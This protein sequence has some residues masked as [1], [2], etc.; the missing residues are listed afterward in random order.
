MLYLT[1]DMLTHIPRIDDAHLS[2]VNQA[3]VVLTA[4]KNGEAQSIMNESI[5]F[6]EKYLSE[7][8]NDEEEL[9]LEMEYPYYYEHHKAHEKIIQQMNFLMEE[10][11]VDAR[12]PKTKKMLIDLIFGVFFDH[13][14]TMDKSLS[15]FVRH[16]K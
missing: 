8:F 16:I 12:S 14:R 10:H 9:Q 3:H 5:R 15:E 7:H 4:F 2:I 6:L 1:D 13:I 11:E